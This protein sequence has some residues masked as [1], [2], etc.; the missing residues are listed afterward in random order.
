RLAVKAI[1]RD[2]DRRL[3]IEEIEYFT[4]SGL[5][6]ITVPR[7]FGG[8]G[9]SNVTL[10]EVTAIISAA[11]PSIGQI[12]QN[13]YCLVDAVRIVGTEDQKNF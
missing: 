8:A 5:W 13:H 12:P 7:A 11:D 1:D 6:G 3:P 10:A 2:R 4:A 9:V